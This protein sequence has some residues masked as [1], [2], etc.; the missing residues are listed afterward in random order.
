[1]IADLRRQDA[2]LIHVDG[3][4][5]RNRTAM[6]LDLAELRSIALSDH[7]RWLELARSLRGQ[8]AIVVMEAGAAVAI[9]DLTGSYP[10]FLLSAPNGAPWKLAT[11]LVELEVDS[12]RSVRRT[13]LFQYVAFGSMDMNQE[14]IYTDISRA[15]AGAVAFFPK[16]MPSRRNTR[17]G[18]PWR[19]RPRRTP[20]APG[21]CSNPSCGPTPNAA[22][23]RFPPPSPWGFCSPAVP[24][25]R[26]LPRSSASRFPAVEDCR[27][28]TQDFSWGRYSELAQARA[29]AAALG[30]QTEPVMLDRTTHFLAV[31]A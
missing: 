16:R 29:N 30:I 27:C 23:I 11:S 5:V 3:V 9:T 22:W 12:K 26:S 25:P 1:M 31:R 14:T 13:A 28:F 8:F 20:I 21:L 19:K 6:A 10:V 2:R 4:P 7:A 24:I 15:P 18:T 17:T